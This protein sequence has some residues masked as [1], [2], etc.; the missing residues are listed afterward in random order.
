MPTR[1]WSPKK[2]DIFWDNDAEPIEPE[3]GPEA[4]GLFGNSQLAGAADALALPGTNEALGTVLGLGQV[5]YDYSLD[6]LDPVDRQ[7]SRP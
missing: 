5:V 4:T 1:K 2:I 3:L 6:E 7:Q